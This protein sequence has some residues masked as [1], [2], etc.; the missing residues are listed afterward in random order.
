VIQR[1][2]RA[3]S[4]E[5]LVQLS[6]DSA[7]SLVYA[8]VVVFDVASWLDAWVAEYPWERSADAAGRMLVRDA[9]KLPAGTWISL[10]KESVA[11]LPIMRETSNDPYAWHKGAAVYEL[12]CSLYGKKLPYTEQDVVAILTSSTHGCGHGADVKPPFETAVAWAR[13]H[14]VTP[15]WLAAVRKFIDGL[16]GL[17]S[18]QANDLKTKGG[19]VL[20]LD[21]TSG[22]KSRCH[23]ECFRRDLGALPS[24]ERIAWE[25]LVLYMGTAMGAR[26]PKG[27]D[28]QASALVTSVG[29]Q[30]VVSRLERWIPQPAAPCRLETAGSHL[31][32]N[33]VWLL[34]TMSGDAAAVAACDSLV[35]RLTRV[36]VTP[37]Q[38]GKKIA[39]ACAVYFAQ[40]PQAIGRQ[41]LQTLLA[42]TETMEKTNYDSDGIRKIVSEYLARR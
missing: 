12:A 37:A 24:E 19:L 16:K 11:R 36:N 40:R 30:Q 31:L 18:V 13:V 28:A 17:R 23:S 9:L 15:A 5:L 38:L 4:R 22:E 41:P 35:E 26:M 14:G 34:L 7:D 10:H 33:L 29:L 6:D 25:R 42:R 8:G 20:H 21:T 2:Q 32:R 27:Y 3:A 39:L 1:R